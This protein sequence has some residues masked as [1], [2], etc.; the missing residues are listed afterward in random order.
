MIDFSHSKV[1]Q[2]HIGKIEKG[3]LSFLYELLSLKE[4]PHIQMSIEIF[5]VCDDD[6]YK[7]KEILNGENYSSYTSVE[8]CFAY[9]NILV[10]K[11][12]DEYS[13]I[14]TLDEVPPCTHDPIIS[15]KDK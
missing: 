10:K 14:L 5:G 6:F 4:M 1:V 3:A 2:Y 11:R 13:H 9:E 8:I 7:L 12:K 15:K